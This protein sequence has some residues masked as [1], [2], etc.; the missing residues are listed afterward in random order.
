MWFF[1]DEE[2]EIQRTCRDFA[3][4]EIAPHAEKH[5]TDET[6]NLDAFKRWES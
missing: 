6:F 2:R 3:A 5:D 4:K 1:T